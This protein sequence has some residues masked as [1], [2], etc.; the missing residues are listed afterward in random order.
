[1]STE[2]GRI[3]LASSYL[4]VGFVSAFLFVV[5]GVLI[6][7]NLSQVVDAQS[8]LILNHAYLGAPLTALM[9]VCTQYGREY[10][11]IPVVALMFLLGSQRTKILAMELAVLFLVGI[12]LG[13]FLKMAIF[14]ARPFESID[15]IMR[16]P[17]DTDSSFPSGHALIVSIGAAFSVLKLKGK[18]LRVLLALEAAVV[19]YSRVYLGLHYPLDVIAGIFL[20]IGI[21]GIGLFVMER[22]LGT[23]LARIGALVPSKLRNGPL[24]L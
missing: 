9:V 13:E 23:I 24:E 11:W 5:V 12:A 7:S 21:V 20:G 16:F 1:M 6:F 2:Q 10:F 19:C 18:V 8:A 3:P 15:M 14:R 4:R 22:Y 17:T